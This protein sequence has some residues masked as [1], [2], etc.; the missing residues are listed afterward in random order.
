MNVV[1]FAE[2]PQVLVSQY[3][4]PTTLIV[5]FE[6]DGLGRLSQ[7]EVDR[8]V[9]RDKSGRPI[10]LNLPQKSVLIANHQVSDVEVSHSTRTD[11]LRMRY[12]PGLR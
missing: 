7:D 12:G 2:R 4:A 6:R 11:S 10:G 3:F 5:S 8:M 9:V 1:H